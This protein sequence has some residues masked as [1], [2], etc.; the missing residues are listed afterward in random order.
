MALS[1]AR[2]RANSKYDKEKRKQILIAIYPPDYDLIDYVKSKGN[3]SGFVKQLIRAEM[4]R[5]GKA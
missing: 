5:E 1:E 4:E 2:K 3:V